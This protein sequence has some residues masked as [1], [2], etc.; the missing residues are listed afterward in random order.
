MIWE[1]EGEIHMVGWPGLDVEYCGRSL[2]L[3][4]VDEVCMT[5]GLRIGHVMVGVGDGWWKD[6]YV[7]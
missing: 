5:T 2:I 3:V 6:F 4:L 1:G 7:A